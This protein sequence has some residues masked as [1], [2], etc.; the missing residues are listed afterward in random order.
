MPSNLALYGAD[1]GYEQTIFDSRECKAVSLPAQRVCD[2]WCTHMMGSCHVQVAPTDCREACCATNVLITQSYK[3]DL[4]S[5]AG[6]YDSQNCPQALEKEEAEREAALAEVA[7]LEA[8][9]EAASKESADA[10]STLEA[11]SHPS[12]SL[13]CAGFLGAL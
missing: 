5:A 7:R 10:T 4:L 2:L 3:H 1:D 8:L 6:T 11:V 9:V 12:V 13:A